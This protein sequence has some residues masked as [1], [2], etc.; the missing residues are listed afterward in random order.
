MNSHTLKLLRMDSPTHHTITTIL[1][2]NNNHNRN[3]VLKLINS[4]SII[5]RTYKY[6]QRTVV[7]SCIITQC[8][9]IVRFSYI[10][11]I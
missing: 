7:H 2:F 4:T 11:N 3:T 6:L 1:I 8:Y 9:I 10:L 5:L